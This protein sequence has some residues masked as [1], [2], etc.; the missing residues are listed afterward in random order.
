MNMRLRVGILAI[1]A[2]LIGV[3]G[4]WISYALHDH[5]ISAIDPVY[6]LLVFTIVS[7]GLF[8]TALFTLYSAQIKGKLDKNS[9]LIMFPL[10]LTLTAVVSAWSVFV[11]VMWWG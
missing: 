2:A 3:F 10:L 11:L 1:A 8:I 7:I 6:Y 4:Q 9:F 5:V